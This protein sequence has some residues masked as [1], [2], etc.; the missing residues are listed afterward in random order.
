MP[1]YCHRYVKEKGT[2]VK[3]ST[4]LIEIVFPLLSGNDVKILIFIAKNSNQS[5]GSLASSR[6]IAKGLYLNQRTVLNSLQHL[7]RLDLIWT[8]DYIHILKVHERDVY[9]NFLCNKALP[10]M[11]KKLKGVKKIKKSGVMQKENQLMH[12]LDQLMQNVHQ[13]D[14]EKSS[15][16]KNVVQKVH[17]NQ[18]LIQERIEEIKSKKEA[19]ASASFPEVIPS[20][21]SSAA[22][23]PQL[24]LVPSTPST[25]PPPAPAGQLPDKEF[26]KE[27]GR[28]LKKVL[29][30]EEAKCKDLDNSTMAKGYFMRGEIPSGFALPAFTDHDELGPM[31]ARFVLLRTTNLMCLEQRDAGIRRRSVPGNQKEAERLADVISSFTYGGEGWT[32]AFQRF[33]EWV[34]SEKGNLALHLLSGYHAEWAGEQT[35]YG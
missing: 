24:E 13:G 29:L 23:P 20:H 35:N 15:E 7:Q 33:Y 12:Y 32:T 28:L 3:V 25:P 22:N 27:Q 31:S 19:S 4:D 1:V 34:I 8:K 16:D 14:A 26:F 10:A 2:F 18:E 21:E 9:I 30:E 5:G 6:F 11:L 17:Q